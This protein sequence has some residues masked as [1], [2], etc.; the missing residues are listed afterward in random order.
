MGEPS[1]DLWYKCSDDDKNSHN[2]LFLLCFIYCYF[3][4][5][6]FLSVLRAKA[7][8]QANHMTLFF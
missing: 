6:S 1:P 7:I 5:A 8:M 4:Q 2:I 3:V